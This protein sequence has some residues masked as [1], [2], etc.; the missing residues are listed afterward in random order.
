VE[1]KKIGDWTEQHFGKRLPVT[2]RKDVADGAIYDDSSNVEHNTGRILAH[3]SNPGDQGKPIL[4][5]LD[6]T[7]AH[8]GESHG[9]AA[10]RERRSKLAGKWRTLRTWR[11]G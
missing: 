7:L 10:Q 8:D 6:G 11:T 5:D 3:T 9:G 2:D 1:R 4:V